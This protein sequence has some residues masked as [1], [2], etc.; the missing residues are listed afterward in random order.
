MATPELQFHSM[1]CPRCGTPLALFGE[2]T[3]EQLE[4]R[5]IAIS[6]IARA[7]SAR[8]QIY[9]P[10]ATIPAYLEVRDAALPIVDRVLLVWPE[11]H[12]S[13]LAPADWQNVRPLLQRLHRCV[14]LAR[15]Y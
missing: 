4:E 10:G 12:A 13:V 14:P 6:Y 8:L 11:E 1:H 9:Q 5:T 15:L 2:T 3:E 7:L